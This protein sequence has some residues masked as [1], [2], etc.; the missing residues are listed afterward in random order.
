MKILVDQN[1]EKHIAKSLTLAGHA[2]LH[3]TEIG[4]PTATDEDLFQYCRDAG[5][6]FITA[7]VKL[8]KFLASS[9]ATSPSVV[10]V[11]DY[12]FGVKQSP[13]LLPDLIAVLSV[14]KDI[15]LGGDHAVFTKRIDR[16]LRLRILPLDEFE[17]TEPFV[18]QMMLFSELYL[19]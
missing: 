1:L 15:L 11:R 19:N 18:D 12:G 3:T 9:K 4:M 5:L 6:L 7:D 2:A 8:T 13:A 10:I 14:V 16:P 17:H